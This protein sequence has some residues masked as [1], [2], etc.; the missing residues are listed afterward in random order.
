MRSRAETE[1]VKLNCAAIAFRF[2]SKVELRSRNGERITG[3]WP[4]ISSVR[5]AI[6][7]VVSRYVN[8][9]YA[10][11]P[12]AKDE[13][14]GSRSAS[15]NRWQHAHYA[16]STCGS[17]TATNRDLRQMLSDTGI[18]RRLVLPPL[19]YLSIS[20]PPPRERRKCGYSGCRAYSLS[21]TRPI[22]WDKAIDASP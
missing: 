9:R 11:G 19:Q 22:Q 20:L 6:T 3:V 8:R 2:Y 17:L 13:P 5:A 16:G 18:S 15:S 21:T 1:L 14:R 10:P 12:S 7:D 4:R